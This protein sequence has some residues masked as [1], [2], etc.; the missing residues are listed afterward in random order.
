MKRIIFTDCK[1]DYTRAYGG[2]NGNKIG[3]IYNNENYMLK[4]PPKPTINKA[5]S[6]TNSCISEHISCKILNE[7]GMNAQKTL[8]GEY[9]NKIV[10]ACKDFTEYNKRFFDFAS[11]KNTIIE[12]EQEG[13]GTELN[14]IL[15]TIENQ[16]IINKDNLKEFFW[17]MFIIDAFLGNFDR[18][19]GNW[20][21]L[22]D[23]DKNI[24][25]A[26]IYDCGSC[27]FPQNDDKQMEESL[28][29]LQKMEDRLYSYPQSVIKIN[30]IKINYYNFLTTT[31]NQD[32]LKSLNK[33][34]KKID[35]IK[36]G[37][38]IDETEYISDTHKKF[39]KTILHERKTKILD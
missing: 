8:L 37:K 7:I 35:L 33:I 5:I 39:I 23:E 34:S 4:F 24:S 16:K 25:I 9:G 29:D 30:N 38:L 22:I 15:E 18:H 21:F 17:D 32:C 28:K 19:N 1:I 2:A 31:D 14:D 26:P 3:I 20:G 36:I 6:Y 10:V 13:Y 11:L 12:S 27:L